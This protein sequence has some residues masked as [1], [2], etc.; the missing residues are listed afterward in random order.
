MAGGDYT[1]ALAGTAQNSTV[2][3][4]WAEGLNVN[5]Y[6]P[7]FGQDPDITVGGLIAYLN[8]GCHISDSYVGGEITVN[9]ENQG[10]L[11]GAYEFF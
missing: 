9:N 3:E 7:I 10:G 2:S 6:G 1:G 5:P 4:V 11:F 8:G